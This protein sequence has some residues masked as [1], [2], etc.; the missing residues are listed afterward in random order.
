MCPQCRKLKRV[1]IFRSRFTHD[2]EGAP[3]RA[4]TL[5]GF[6]G[7]VCRKCYGAL[8][9]IPL[10]DPAASTSTSITVSEAHTTKAVEV[11]VC[12]ECKESKS[13]MLAA[14]TT[15]P[16][17]QMRLRT[18]PGFVGT[19]CVKCYEERYDEGRGDLKDKEPSPD[20]GAGLSWQDAV[21][22]TTLSGSGSASNVRAG[23]HSSK[24][25]SKQQH[26]AALALSSLSAAEAPD[27]QHDSDSGSDSGM[28]P[29]V[30]DEPWEPSDDAPR[31]K[32]QKRKR[33]LRGTDA[34]GHYLPE[35][36][37][38]VIER[39]LLKRQHSIDR[40][41]SG[42]SSRKTFAEIRPRQR[43]RF[44]P[45]LPN[46]SEEIVSSIRSH[47]FQEHPDTDE[48]AQ[49]KNE[50]ARDKANDSKADLIV[51]DETSGLF[52]VESVVDHQVKNKKLLYRFVF[53]FFFFSFLS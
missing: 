51:G 43:G 1:V 16:D 6:V 46:V 26:S 27:S 39:F 49:H 20:G 40:D 48:L 21:L 11:R 14:P 9:P 35:K 31:S 37:R 12:S 38:R 52:E 33:R 18:R 50:R 45:L 53:F 10:S 32:S 7:S 25:D 41:S 34:D 3:R 13:A 23:E 19:M 47:T 4:R 42:L 30:E 24:E 28:K 15:E 36:R 22:L 44:L 5:P 2:I 8:V 29:K 17:T